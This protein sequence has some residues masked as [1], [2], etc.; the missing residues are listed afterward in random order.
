[1]IIH[2]TPARPPPFI[3]RAEQE[4]N[5]PAARSFNLANEVEQVHHKL[6]E[7]TLK[8]L[9]QKIEIKEE[10]YFVCQ[11]CGNTVAGEAPEVCPVCG[12]KHDQFKKVD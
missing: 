2:T 1:M 9:Q 6:F 8:A 5:A 12:S 11:V 7:E 4:Q 3:D 10:T